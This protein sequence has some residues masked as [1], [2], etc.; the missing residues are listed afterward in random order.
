MHQT[1]LMHTNIHK[2][3]KIGH[4]SDR[5]FQRHTRNQILNLLHTFF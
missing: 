5:A 1:V 2:R 4:V 3:A